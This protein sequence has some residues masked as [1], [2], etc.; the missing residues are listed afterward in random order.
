MPATIRLAVP[1]DA[2]LLPAI[3]TCAAQAFLMMDELKWLAES[4][5]MS[6]ERHRQLIALSTCWVAVDDE[7]RPQGF[8]SAERHGRDLHIHELSVMQ[9]MQ[10]QGT[11]RLLIEAAKDYARFSRLASVT[12]TTFKNVPWNA[13]FY[14]RAGFQ[15]KATADLDQRLATIVSEEYQH[16]FAAGSRCAMAWVVD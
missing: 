2:E 9:S 11:G 10:G 5:P 3:E 4:P 16:G 1:A 15:I 6:V 12:L 8:L 14:A 7:N 13:P